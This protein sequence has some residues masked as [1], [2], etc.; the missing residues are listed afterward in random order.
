MPVTSLTA[1]MSYKAA[2]AYP[3]VDTA[4]KRSR[5]STSSVAAPAG[6]SAAGAGSCCAGLESCGGVLLVASRLVVQLVVEETAREDRQQDEEALVDRHREGH[7]SGGER[8]V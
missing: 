2:V 4:L 1:G 5:P 3:E 8:G 7:S 6:S